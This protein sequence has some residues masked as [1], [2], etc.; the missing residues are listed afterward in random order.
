MFQVTS[1]KE[2]SSSSLGDGTENATENSR[3]LSIENKLF[4]MTNVLAKLGES[5]FCCDSKKRKRVP[6]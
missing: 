4:I 6:E 2:P 5:K 1:N 3:F